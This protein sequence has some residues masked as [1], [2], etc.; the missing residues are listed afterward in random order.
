[1]M[2]RVADPAAGK[3][4]TEVGA[5]RATGD[6]VEERYG[7]SQSELWRHTQRVRFKEC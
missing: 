2:Y 1:M 3:S 4:R 5:V 7:G 6:I